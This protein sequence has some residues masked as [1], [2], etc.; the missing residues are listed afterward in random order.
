MAT[1]AEPEPGT[2]WAARNAGP[3]T[4]SGRSG[5][6]QAGRLQDRRR[7]MNAKRFSR[8][9][10]VAVL[11]APLAAAAQAGGSRMH[12]GGRPIYD[13]GTVTTSTW[14]GSRAAT[15]RAST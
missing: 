8:L 11:V 2:A 15:T 10:L 4:G 13:V 12:G 14:P 6:S 1:T 5:A 7:I 9:A 3:S